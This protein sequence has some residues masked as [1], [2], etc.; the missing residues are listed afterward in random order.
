M[1]IT[2]AHAC[3]YFSLF[4]QILL[5]KTIC[6]ISLFLCLSLVNIIFIIIIRYIIIIIIIIYHYKISYK[7]SKYLEHLSA[8]VCPNA[9]LSL[10]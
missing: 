5:V 10:S 8:S 3:D 6:L 1:P 7:V 2:F 9:S 4:V